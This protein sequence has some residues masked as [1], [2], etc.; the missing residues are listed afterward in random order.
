MPAP[1]K[2]WTPL[3]EQS[4]PQEHRFLAFAQWITSYFDHGDLGSRDL[5]VLSYWIPS[6]SRAPTVFN[7]PP[8]FLDAHLRL[9]ADAFFDMYFIRGMQEQMKA[10]H[11]AAFFDD[12]TRKLFGRMKV[13]LLTG[14]R[15]PAWGPAGMWALQDEEKELK[16]EGSI[17]FKVIPGGNHFVRLPDPLLPFCMTDCQATDALGRTRGHARRVPRSD[18]SVKDLSSHPV[19]LA[20]RS[21]HLIRRHTVYL[22]CTVA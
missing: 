3:G 9:D 14:D 12:A 22:Y 1:P 17:V 13:W 15:A 20:V 5:D 18:G 7:I 16:K 11:R 2:N 6:S 19:C 8:A 10:S 21:A 4:I